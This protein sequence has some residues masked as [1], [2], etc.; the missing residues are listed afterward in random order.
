VE[1]LLGRASLRV[2]T[3]VTGGNVIWQPFATASG[4]RA[5]AD[6]VTTDFRTCLGAGIVPGLLG[7][8][9]LSSPDFTAS[10]T[11]G[12]VGTYGQ[13]AVGVA[14]QVI[15]TG[16]LGYIRGDFR[17]GENI[18]GWSVNGGL[19]YQFTPSQIAAAPITKG[20]VKAPPAPVVVATNWTGFYVGG[21]ACPHQGTVTVKPPY[22]RRRSCDTSFRSL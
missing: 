2:G 22:R 19:R 21:F 13:F 8:C 15:D 20:I 10:L 4:F 7:S 12:G 9:L 5:F 14:G 16:W 1:S 11:T 17:T 18:D 3:T 6:P